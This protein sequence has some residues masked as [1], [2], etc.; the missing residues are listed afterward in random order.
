MT[1]KFS[2]TT[3]ERVVFSGDA[4]Y[5]HLNTALGEIGIYPNHTPLVSIVKPGVVTVRQGSEEHYL[6]VSGGYV[7]VQANTVTVLADTAERADEINVD[8]A[9][10]AR[11]RAQQLMSETVK[12]ED[13]D[14]AGL[15]SKME[16]ELARVR[17][18][19]KKYRDV[20]R[21]NAV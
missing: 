11:A 6:A 15:A 20:G 13:V 7:E 8:R 21:P 2:I 17:A 5:L 16:K 14:Y 10:A 1:L 3:P 9:E 19:R 4:D 18:A 12:H